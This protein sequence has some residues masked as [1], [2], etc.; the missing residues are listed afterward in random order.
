MYSRFA[1][2]LLVAVTLAAA[3]CGGVTDPSKNKTETFTGTLTIGGSQ[4]YSFNESNSGEY[5]VTLSSLTPSANVF[6]GLLIGQ[7]TSSG[8]VTIQQNNLSTVGFQSL[9]G[10]IIPGS[11]CVII[12]D[13][14]TLTQ[15]V[16]F[17]VSISHP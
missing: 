14:G 6:I 9:G 1:V 13:V 8:C 3:A 2:A 17:S 4:L 11:Y 10:A 5:T 7:N 16:N 15:S 12:F